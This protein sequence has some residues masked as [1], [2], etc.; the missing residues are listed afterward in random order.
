MAGN[1]KAALFQHPQLDYFNACGLNLQGVIDIAA[2]PHELQEQ[3]PLHGQQSWRQLLLLGHGGRYLWQRLEAHGLI[4]D[5]VAAEADPVDA[6]SLR[7][8]ADYFGSQQPGVA[9]ACIYPQRADVP[10]A[11]SIN[12]QA[13]GRWL[14]WHQDSPL[15]VGINPVWGSWFAYRALV[16][17]DTDLPVSKPVALVSPCLSCV[18]KPCVSQ[19]P[20]GAVQAHELRLADCIDWRRQPQS[21]CVNR[22]LARAACPVAAQHAY[23]DSQRRYHYDLSL[24]HIL[25]YVDAGLTRPSTD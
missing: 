17:A 11:G 7:C 2:L 6:Y 3:L 5:G 4:V 25:R 9:F 19:C 13:L 10:S 16:L 23:T 18:A 12:L 14:G 22:C 8:V 24:Q 1:D 20:A 15:R 21:T